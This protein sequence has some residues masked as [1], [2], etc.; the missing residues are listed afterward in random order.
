MPT[1]NVCGNATNGC[2]HPSHCT[3]ITPTALTS[4]APFLS[5][6]CAGRS[7]L[8]THLDEE[9]VRSRA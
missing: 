7:T 8:K 6:S 9:A 2:K 5:A 4:F 1:S 3:L